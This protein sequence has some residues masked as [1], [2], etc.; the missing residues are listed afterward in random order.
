MIRVNNNFRFCLQHSAAETESSI[1]PD[2][3]QWR[4]FIS[5]IPLRQ[6]AV[7][8]C[9]AFSTNICI[10]KYI[11]FI[12]DMTQF[13]PKRLWEKKHRAEHAGC[14]DNSRHNSCDTVAGLTLFHSLKG[15]QGGGGEDYICLRWS[16]DFSHTLQM[17]YGTEKVG[18]QWE[19]ESVNKAC[20]TVSWEWEGSSKWGWLEWQLGGSGW[21]LI[22]SSAVITYW[23]KHLPANI[24]KSIIRFIAFVQGYWLLFCGPIL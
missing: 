3:D 12:T 14:M 22:C 11:L 7:F 9:K 21:G 2:K 23:K 13:H 1:V 6:Q 20:G 8:T 19:G 4:T 15:L 16:W 18:I 5:W 10:H 24:F 17:I